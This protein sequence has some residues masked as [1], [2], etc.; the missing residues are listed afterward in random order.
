MVKILSPDEVAGIDGSGDGCFQSIGTAASDF[1]TG[2]GQGIKQDPFVALALKGLSEIEG[3]DQAGLAEIEA[4]ANNSTAAQFGRFIGEYAPTLLLGIPLMGGGAAAGRIAI[5]GIAKKVATQAAAKDMLAAA[6]RAGTR[7]PRLREQLTMVSAR[8]ASDSAGKTALVQGLPVIQRGAQSLGVNI[9]FTNLIATQELA[10]GKPP[11][12]ALETAAHSMALFAGVDMALLGGVKLLFPGSRAVDLVAK[13]EQ[14]IKQVKEGKLKGRSPIGIL[15]HSVE[16][17]KT[18]RQEMADEVFKVLK[19]EK[20]QLELFPVSKSQRLREALNPPKRPDEPPGFRELFKGKVKE[21]PGLELG[22]PEGKEF[23][24]KLALEAKQEAGELKNLHK[25]ALDAVKTREA[26]GKKVAGLM[27]KRNLER[28]KILEAERQLKF[29]GTIP[30]I[31]SGPDYMGPISKTL[32]WFDPDGKLRFGLTSA[33]ESAFGKLGPVGN[34]LFTPLHRGLTLADKESVIA[35]KAYSVWSERLRILMGEKSSRVWRNGYGKQLDSSHAWESLEFGGGPT[36][37]RNQME[38]WKRPNEDIE[39]AIAIF[40]AMED[41]DTQ[42]L[43]VK[44]RQVGAKRALNP[45]DFG[46]ARFITHASRDIPDEELL[47]KLVKDGKMTEA[48]AHEI[49]TRSVEH[50]DPVPLE[51]I[52][53]TRPGRLGPYD[54]YRVKKG[55]YKEK[56]EQGLPMNPAVFDARLRV[57]Q[58]AYRRIHIDPILGR[59]VFNKK[60]GKVEGDRIPDLVKAVEA[61][62]ENAAKFRTVLDTVAGRTYYNESMR[63]VATFTTSLQVAAKLPMAVLPNASQ[64]LLTATMFGFRKTLRAVLQ[65]TRK[66]SREEAAVQ[67]AIHTHM[68]R[69]VGRTMDQ[70]GLT[71]TA[72]EKFADHT[73][74]FTGFNDVER[75][76]RIISHRAAQAVIRDTLAKGY[77]DRLK[78]V[79]LDTGRRRLGEL[80][81]D[82]DLSVRQMKE[83]GPDA[84]FNSSVFLRQEEAATR[85]G[86]QKTQFF[87]SSTRTPTFWRHPLGRIMFQFKTFAIG[88]GRFMRDVVLTEYAHGNV[89]PL[90]TFLSFA[91]IAGELVGDAKSL[92]TGRNRD[93]NGIVRALENASMI[94]GIGLASDVFAQAK[95]GRLESVYLGPT[96]SDMNDLFEA[97]ISQG[98]QGIIN[99]MQRQAIY[100]L[101]DFLTGTIVEGGLSAAEQIEEYV[102]TIGD[103]GGDSTTRVDIGQRLTERI[104]NKR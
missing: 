61:S 95:W 55:S 91:P 20:Q 67:Y 34:R 42:V 70:E 96:I 88:Q 92:I 49:M 62:G 5:Q 27:D 87:P 32:D 54:W 25:A 37:L 102:D 17:M 90:A 68:M 56:V 80:G 72:A 93:T 89:A 57:I 73:L 6:A 58:S 3:I 1:G 45:A 28:S 46:N 65:S 14:F 11:V 59:R 81:V 99:L 44:G 66:S 50:L 85:L 30:Y 104:Q 18:T 100:K 36:G 78:G 29:E 40:K 13:R 64:T 53:G 24:R 52:E 103:E 69:G 22:K 7:L 48:E 21:T 74:R 83:V 35:E 60:T 2:L 47:K 82:L 33:G 71:L 76:N 10:R 4:Y 19:V 8:A 43:L 98:G 79:N 39:E 12:E 41:M 16:N 26:T 101:G 15:A 75:F 86:A 31:G 9:A 51:G 38:R 63:K 94:G 23:R 97:S 77:K 84:F